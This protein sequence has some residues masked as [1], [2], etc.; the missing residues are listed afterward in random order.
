MSCINAVFFTDINIYVVLNSFENS[1][2]LLRPKIEVAI[3][4][5]SIFTINKY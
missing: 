4:F 2:F 1:F 5:N 3:L